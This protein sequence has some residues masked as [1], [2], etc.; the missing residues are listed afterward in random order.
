MSSGEKGNIL[1]VKTPDPE[2]RDHT[3]KKNLYAQKLGGSMSTMNTSSTGF[4]LLGDDDSLLKEMRAEEASLLR[5]AIQ[6]G[7]EE[8]PLLYKE[9]ESGGE[10]TA[11]KKLLVVPSGFRCALKR[12]VVSGSFSSSNVEK[13]LA[14]FA[15]E[16]S[17]LHRLADCPHVIDVFDAEI[18][19]GETG[20]EIRIVMEL[21]SQ[22]FAGFLESRLREGV[23]SLAE[24]EKKLAEE[25][26]AGGTY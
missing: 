13:R 25:G 3:K 4:S 2:H 26:G 19:K 24:E 5:G 7:E 18:E 14:T 8:S 21:A 15:Q 9:T 22:D 20:G 16:L 10:E 17:A 11:K 6:G 1:L 23:V 12:V